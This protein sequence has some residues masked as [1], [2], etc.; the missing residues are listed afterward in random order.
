MQLLF[1]EPVSNEPELKRNFKATFAFIRDEVKLYRP[2][3]V[4]TVAP[5][6]PGQTVALH[7][8]EVIE[9]DDRGVVAW[10]EISPGER[11]RTCLPATLLCTCGHGPACNFEWTPQGDV[12]TRRGLPC[13]EFPAPGP[14]EQAEEE[15][16]RRKFYR[17]LL[18]RKRHSD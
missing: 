18:C 16:L 9:V 15:R 3:T 6:P 11:V 14:D 10:V 17:N 8:G 13:R 7:H 12:R 2:A 1:V 4:A 5:D